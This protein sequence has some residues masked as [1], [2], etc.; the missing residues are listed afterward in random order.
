MPHSVV[1]WFRLVGAFDPTHRTRL[2]YGPALQFFRA[3][4]Q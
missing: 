2:A 3:F 4:L 1:S